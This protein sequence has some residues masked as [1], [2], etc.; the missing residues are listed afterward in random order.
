MPP[1][2]LLREPVS[3]SCAGYMAN[4]CS[5][6][7]TAS[8][9]QQLASTGGFCSFFTILCGAVHHPVNRRTHNLARINRKPCR[10]VT[11]LS[12]AMDARHIASRQ[13]EP[14][15]PPSGTLPGRFLRSR[16]PTLRQARISR[17]TWV[18]RRTGSAHTGTL[19]V[20]AQKWPAGQ[21]AQGA[22]RPSR[23]EAGA[24]PGAA[25]QV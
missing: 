2:P 8:E 14:S 11:T 16:Q 5:T 12:G 6:T 22:E 10:H 15:R 3:I 7:S 19:N 1:T 9:K 20:L 25:A 4:T 24:V 21:A 13:E 17:D 18:L 23:P